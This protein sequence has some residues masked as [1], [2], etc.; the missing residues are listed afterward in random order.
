MEKFKAMTP[1]ERANELVDKM[2]CARVIDFRAAKQVALIACDEII[3]ELKSIEFNYDLNF[4]LDL[5][6]YY[7]DVKTE[8]ENL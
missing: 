7:L 4:Q 8:I 6:P 2:Y 3:E 1:K 5:I